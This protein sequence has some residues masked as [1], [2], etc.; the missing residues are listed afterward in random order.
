MPPFV[1]GIQYGLLLATLVGPLVFLLIQASLERGRQGGFTAG[2]G[3]W[4][5]DLICILLVLFWFEPLAT[6]SQQVWFSWSLG[7]GG[8]LLLIGMGLHQIRTTRFSSNR[9]NARSFVYDW[10]Q[11]FLVN[12][13]NPFTFFFWIV[14]IS[15]VIVPNNYSFSQSVYFFLGLLSTIITTD[16]CKILFAHHVHEWIHRHVKNIRFFNGIL[17]L[18]FGVILFLRVFL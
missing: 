6:L 3:I 5:S 14:M 16:S 4:T 12:T 8:G 17:F 1:L 7:G 9:Y 15:E 18:F 2:S 13:I 11:G 10:L